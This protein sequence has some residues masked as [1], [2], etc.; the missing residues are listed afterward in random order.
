MAVGCRPLPLYAVYQA[1]VE[2]GNVFRE[3]AI[4]EITIWGRPANP[5]SDG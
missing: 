2:D 3:M 4:D 5:T 1:E